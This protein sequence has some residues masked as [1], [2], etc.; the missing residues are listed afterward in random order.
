MSEL[1]VQHSGNL[2]RR[3]VEEQ[4]LGS[5]VT[6]DHAGHLVVKLPEC[7]PRRRQN[8][9]RETLVDE[10]LPVTACHEGQRN[11]TAARVHLDHLRDRHSVTR[12]NQ[13]GNLGA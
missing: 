6:V 3:R 12:T 2:P 7:P 8:L 9:R 13:H 4:V 11:L 10:F 5:V 1:P